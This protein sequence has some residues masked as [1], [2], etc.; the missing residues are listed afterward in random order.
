MADRLRT[1][2]GESGAKTPSTGA[3]SWRRRTSP[4]RCQDGQPGG[5]E[6]T[7][8][9]RH[10]RT[11]RVRGADRPPLDPSRSVRLSRLGPDAVAVYAG[12]LEGALDSAGIEFCSLGPPAVARPRTASPG[13]PT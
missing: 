13:W 11:G 8:R 12:D 1:E 6:A 7:P 2:Y 9:Q 10:V 5:G 4:A 3:N